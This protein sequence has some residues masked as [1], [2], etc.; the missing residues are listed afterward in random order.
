M[1]SSVEILSKMI[2]FYSSFSVQQTCDKVSSTR[3]YSDFL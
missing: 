2:I 1:L 3:N